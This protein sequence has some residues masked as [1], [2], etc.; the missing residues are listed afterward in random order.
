MGVKADEKPNIDELRLRLVPI[1]VKHKV[2]RAS[3]FGS[4]ATGTAGKTSDIDI[5]VE[6][7]GDRSLLDMAALKF[8]IESG[9]NRKA[10]V[11]TYRALHPLIKKKVL[12]QEVRI[13]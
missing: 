5:L 7:S 9:I 13:L 11:L 12:A 10:D 6:F 4:V 2:A 3:L 1:L 8:D